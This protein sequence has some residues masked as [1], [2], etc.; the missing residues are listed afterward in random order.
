MT[1]TSVVPIA[2]HI[3]FKR[4]LVSNLDSIRGG[5]AIQTKMT[6][7]L[8]RPHPSSLSSVPDLAYAWRWGGAA[9]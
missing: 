8:V 4:K 5:R 3:C 1:K 2:C 9:R 6:V 7:F